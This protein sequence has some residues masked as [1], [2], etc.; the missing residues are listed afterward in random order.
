M[1]LCAEC[2][3]RP[4]FYF[5][6]AFANALQCSRP[7]NGHVTWRRKFMDF[8]RQVVRRAREELLGCPYIVFVLFL[9]WPLLLMHFVFN[10][11]VKVARKVKVKVKSLTWPLSQTVTQ[12]NRQAWYVTS[13]PPRCKKG[14]RG[15]QKVIFFKTKHYI[16]TWAE[17]CFLRCC[18]SLVFFFFGTEGP[19]S[20]KSS[21]WVQK[22]IQLGQMAVSR[23]IPL[24]TANKQVI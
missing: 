4:S 12:A 10:R 11:P 14:Q 7:S 20:V 15:T 9:R 13:P 19:E 17:G 16:Q 5:P 3:W 21:I 24:I 8:Q 1:G 22:L 2:V 23:V 18:R 6:C